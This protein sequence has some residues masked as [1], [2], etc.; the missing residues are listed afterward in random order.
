MK[1]IKIVTDSTVQLSKAEIKDHSITIIPLS[2]MLNATIYVDEESLSRKQFLDKM[3]TSKLLPKTSQPPIGK[4][5]EAYNELGEDGSSVLAILAAGYLSGTLQAAEQAANLSKTKV[6]VINSGMVDRALSFQVLKAAKLA[7]QGFSIDQIS[8]ELEITKKN[9]ELFVGIIHLDN[10]IKGGRIG[11]VIGGISTLMN[12]K[13]LLR[14]TKT[15]LEPTAKVRGM[16]SLQKKVDELIEQMTVY[17][18]I[19][20]IGV[21]HVGLTTFTEEVI[22]QLKESFP[23]V[24]PYVEYASPTFMTHAGKE[25]FAI[26]FFHD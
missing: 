9:S 8:E 1:K 10:L 5:V 15:G 19:K 18:D 17:S 26:S 25:A 11:K 7:E 16:K 6:T 23:N 24:I 2:S 22:E 4:F 20:E 14:F 13:L 21:T 3:N 12:V